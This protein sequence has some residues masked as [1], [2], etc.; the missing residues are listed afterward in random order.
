MVVSQNKTWICILTVFFIST[1]LT[2]NV[3]AQQV[4][5]EKTGSKITNGYELIKAMKAKYEGKWFKA[6]TIEQKMTYYAPDGKESFSQT[7]NEVVQ[8]PG[9]V[10]ITFGDP[11]NK[12]YEIYVNDTFYTY[13][14]G[15]LKQETRQIHN[16]LVLGFDV[17]V[18]N[19]EKTSAQ[20]KEA[21]F[22][23]GI[24]RETTWQGHSVYVVGA[25]EG[26]LY[27]NQFW[28]DKEYLYCL[29]IVYNT[30]QKS[31][32]HIEFNNYKSLGGGW[33]ATQL[34]FKQNGLKKIQEDY[35]KYSIPDKIDPKLFEIKKQLRNVYLQKFVYGLV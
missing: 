26:D 14:R 3:I 13:E 20:L 10:R 23:L 17:Y 7:S 33:I 18:Q 32:I 30:Q 34:I 1:F 31:I 6:I 16:V 11:K 8:L 9:K 21:S 29:R 2:T 35:I 19:P 24:L 22:D 27:T 15:V 4:P 12:N 25:R 5:T 28:V